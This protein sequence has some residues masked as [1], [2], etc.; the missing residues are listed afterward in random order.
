MA[1]ALGQSTPRGL[2]GEPS[3]HLFGPSGSKARFLF[4]FLASRSDIEKTSLFRTLKN[5]PRW[6]NQST[7]GRPRSV[8][9]PKIRRTPLGCRACQT[10][11][12]LPAQLV[13]SLP[14]LPPHRQKN[15]P[16]VTPGWINSGIFFIFFGFK[17]QHRF[18]HAFFPS[19]LLTKSILN[20]H[21]GPSWLP[22]SAF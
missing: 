14:P 19:I 4:D 10:E 3:L 9:G 18:W 1:A 21:L 20:A 17:F 12:H 6:H 13:S 11:Q 22:F 5:R 16:Q 15:R 8:F 7:L 2:F